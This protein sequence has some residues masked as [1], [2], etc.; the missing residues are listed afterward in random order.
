MKQ[1]LHYLPSIPLSA[2]T[3]C[4]K[5][6]V[7]ASKWW[8]YL[9]N[10]QIQSD[11]LLMSCTVLFTFPF[12]KYNLIQEVTKAK[13]T[14]NT[15]NKQQNEFLNYGLYSTNLERKA[16]IFHFYFFL[17]AFPRSPNSS[18]WRLQ[19]HYGQNIMIHWGRGAVENLVTLPPFLSW[20]NIG[21]S[22]MWSAK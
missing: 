12:K 16:D 19:K 1:N 11:V 14:P 9:I 20:A 17:E 13:T 7:N 15:Q 21:H 4:K 18:Y 6:A 3:P 2:F 5:A 8:F 22:I 10:M